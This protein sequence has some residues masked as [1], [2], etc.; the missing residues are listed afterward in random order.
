M[1]RRATTQPTAE[2]FETEAL[3]SGLKAQWSGIIGPGPYDQVNYAFRDD[4]Y[5]TDVHVFLTWWGH[6]RFTEVLP[7]LDQLVRSIRCVPDDG[8]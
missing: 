8:S 4:A 3:G 6:D 1:T 7:D 2:W 5:D